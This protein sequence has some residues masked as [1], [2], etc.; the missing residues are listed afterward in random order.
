MYILIGAVPRPSVHLCF[1]PPKSASYFS[2]GRIERQCHVRGGILEVAD[3]AGHRNCAIL[4]PGWAVSSH[5]W[6]RK[7][8][9]STKIWALS[10]KVVLCPPSWGSLGGGGGEMVL[11][12]A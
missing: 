8:E 1:V 7:R 10:G 3:L 9:R 4:L 12:M 5:I 2:P 11:M 6:W